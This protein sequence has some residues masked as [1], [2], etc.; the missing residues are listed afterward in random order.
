MINDQLIYYTTRIRTLNRG[1]IGKTR[2]PHKPLFLLSI[3][4]LIE[5]TNLQKNQIPI[6]DAL[7]AIF[8]ENWEQLVR[9][10][11][12]RCFIDNLMDSGS[13]MIPLVIG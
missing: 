12:H 10:K 9:T 7:K 5:A 3:I 1:M 11:N 2:A 13:R 8:I 6:N 4:D